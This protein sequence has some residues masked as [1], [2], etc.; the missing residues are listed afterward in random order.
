MQR[1]RVAGALSVFGRAILVE[2][3]GNFLLP[4]DKTLN[5]RLVPSLAMAI[6]H[7]AQRNK[8]SLEA[9]REDLQK[10]WD[11]VETFIRDTFYRD[12]CE[13]SDYDVILNSA[14][15]NLFG[16]VEICVKT[17]E[18]KLGPQPGWWYS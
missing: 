8:H 15:L 14:T 3:G 16:A 5:V 13:A 10:R 1:L 4:V 17:F 9:A 18:S 7:H 11:K 6:P 12:L 2:M